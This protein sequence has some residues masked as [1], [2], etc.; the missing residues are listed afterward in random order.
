MLTVLLL[1]CLAAFWC[2][3]VVGAV[4]T[5][6]MKDRELDRLNPTEKGA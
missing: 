2:G 1:I 4:F 6:H 5:H 3:V